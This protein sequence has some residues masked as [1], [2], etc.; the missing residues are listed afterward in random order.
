MWRRSGSKLRQTSASWLLGI[1]TTAS[2]L[3]RCALCTR[4]RAQLKSSLE[5]YELRE[6]HFDKLL[7]TKVLEKQLAEAQAAQQ[8]QAHK[9]DLLAVRMVWWLTTSAVAAPATRPHTSVCHRPTSVIRVPW[10]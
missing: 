4:L 7:Q 6:K 2:A 8:L 10:R 3:I 1:L 5:Q 9:A